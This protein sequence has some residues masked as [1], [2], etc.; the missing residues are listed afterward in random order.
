MRVSPG[1]RCARSEGSAG[2][3]QDEVRLSNKEGSEGGGESDFY[4]ILK[5]IH[6]LI[7]L[8]KTCVTIYRDGSRHYWELGSEVFCPIAS[9]L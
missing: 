2:S 5:E 7:N 6:S 1:P 4:D 8:D 9:L 3:I